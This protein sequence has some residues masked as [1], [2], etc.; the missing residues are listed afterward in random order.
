MQQH[1]RRES[2]LTDDEHRLVRSTSAL[3][4]LRTSSW[5]SVA[6]LLLVRGLNG[7]A[8][9]AMACLSRDDSP[10]LIDP[11]VPAVITELSSEAR[12]GPEEGSRL[13]GR[14]LARAAARAGR[15]ESFAAVRALAALSPELGYPGGT[16]G[17]AYDA[18][19]WLDCDCHLG[20]AERA[21]AEAL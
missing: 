15:T 1:E 2:V 7:E 3:G 20:S 14:A 12:R 10:W 6:A 19:E 4:L 5:P 13:V 18:S 9:V 8:T 16:I 11:I 21:A 17:E